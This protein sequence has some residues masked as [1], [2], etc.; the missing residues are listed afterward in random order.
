MRRHRSRR[1]LASANDVPSLSCKRRQLVPDRSCLTMPDA[2]Y[3]LNELADLVDIYLVALA[4]AALWGSSRMST[5]PLG[6]RARI[7]H[8]DYARRNRQ[9]ACCKV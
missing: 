1:L 3:T 4:G 2:I 7:S 5:E 6:T 8:R 9:A